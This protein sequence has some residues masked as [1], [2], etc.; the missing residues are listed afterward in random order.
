[1]GRRL[2]DIVRRGSRPTYSEGNILS[3]LAIRATPIYRRVRHYTTQRSHQKEPCAPA[4]SVTRRWPTPAAG[5][6][7]IPAPRAQAEPTNAKLPPRP[8]PDLTHI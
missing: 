3:Q 2:R 4:G 6:R 7:S 1:M 5:L 8:H